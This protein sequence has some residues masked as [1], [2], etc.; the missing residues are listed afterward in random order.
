MRKNIQKIL[1][2]HEGKYDFSMKF[3]HIF[4]KFKKFDEFELTPLYPSSFAARVE[5]KDIS[6]VNINI[7]RNE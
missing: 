7:L 4:L 2:M 6:Y 5:Y 3:L 1:R